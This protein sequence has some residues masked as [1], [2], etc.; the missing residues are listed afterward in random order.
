MKKKAI[1]FA[2]AFTVL[3]ATV[4]AATGS[5][6]T[7]TLIQQP[8]VCNGSTTTKSV[9]S[10]NGTTYVPLREFGSLT[11]TS[12][13]YQNGK[14]YVGSNNT[15][16]VPVN[17]ASKKFTFSINGISTGINYDDKQVAII[18]ISMKNNSGES[19]TPLG[20]LYD[21]RAYQ[22]GVELE[23]TFDSDLAPQDEYTSVMNGATLNFKSLFVLRDSSPVTVEI[24]EF[25]G[26][27]KVS[28]TFNL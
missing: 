26:N 16:D 22:S 7:A 4:G 11:G 5:K 6:I 14:V 1:L 19:T 28:K 13:N 27:D 8:I 24:T 17:V 9:I 23:S 12:I 25:L 18:D 2:M 21:I 20:S 10:Y 3:G 15:V